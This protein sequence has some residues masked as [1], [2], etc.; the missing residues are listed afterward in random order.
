MGKTTEQ[1]GA[2]LRRFRGHAD[3]QM[4]LPTGPLVFD[5]ALPTAAQLVRGSEVRPP[6]HIPAEAA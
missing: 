6:A 3:W 2:T 4:P 5:P 1:D